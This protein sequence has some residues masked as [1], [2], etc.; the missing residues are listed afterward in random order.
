MLHNT[1]TEK[2]GEWMNGKAHTLNGVH[3]I[4]RYSS[5]TASYPYPHSVQSIT[6]NAS[7]KGKRSKAYKDIKRALGDDYTTDL[8][9]SENLCDIA[10]AMGITNEEIDRIIA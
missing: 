6:H 7:A 1:F 3:G 5:Y 2:L 4:I 8:T 9:Q 10:G